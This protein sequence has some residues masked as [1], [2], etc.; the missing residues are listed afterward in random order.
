MTFF[1]ASIRREL[2]NYHR[3]PS[4]VLNPL[5]FYGLVV[6]LSVIAV[7]PEKGQ[8]VQV[9]PAFIWTAALLA[10]LMSADGVFRNDYEDGSL[11][12]VVVSGKSLAVYVLAKTTA[13]W[14]VTVVPLVLLMPLL[15]ITLFFDF[16]SIWVLCLG[17]VLVTPTLSILGAVG[18]AIT[19]GLP[20]NGML[21]FVLIL[22]FYVPP[23]IFVT[24]M[25]QAS[26]LGEA[27]LPFVYWLLGIFF[28]AIALAPM[29]LI[30]CLRMAAED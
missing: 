27:I 18:A 26:Q 30:A 8:L 17:I 28:L 13:H 16:R 24:G 11:E 7:G 6:F 21:T 5:V 15:G 14:I 25:I 4:L 12:L 22:P 2:I 20:R 1:K 19:L 23:L 3:K 29:V 9:A 10:I